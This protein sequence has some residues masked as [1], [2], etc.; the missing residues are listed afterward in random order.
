MCAPCPHLGDAGDFLPLA[1]NRL[2]GFRKSVIL[3]CVLLVSGL[4]TLGSCVGAL[5]AGVVVIVIGDLLKAA[6]IVDAGT[7]CQANLCEVGSGFS[8]AK[9]KPHLWLSNSNWR[10][11]SLSTNLLFSSRSVQPNKFLLTPSSAVTP[12][13]RSDLV[14][15]TVVAC[16]PGALTLNVDI[17]PTESEQRNTAHFTDSIRAVST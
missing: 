5:A 1:D 13:T 14:S 6:G 9:S 8:F 2:R 15:S 16:R 17:F 7:S 3:F 10:A 12:C 4:E 11:N